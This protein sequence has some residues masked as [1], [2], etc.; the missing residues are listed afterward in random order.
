MTPAKGKK[1]ASSPAARRKATVAARSSTSGAATGASRKPAAGKAASG[2]T[3]AKKTAARKASGA[4]TP[5]R[6]TPARKTPARKSSS[7]KIA[8]AKSPAKK[9]P[10]KKSPA[11]KSP[12]KKSP[13]RKSADRT[14]RATKPA[15]RG[16]G[17]RKAAGG[18][19]SSSTATKKGRGA[20]TASP[21]TPAPKTP[22]PSTAARKKAAAASTKQPTAPSG[23]PRRA[24]DRKPLIRRGAA[25]SAKTRSR[26]PRPLK[27]DKSALKG[28]RER[29][30]AELDNLRARIEDIDETVFQGT[31]S[32]VT[33]EAG[34]DEA[35]ADAGTATFERER[36]LSIRNNIGDLIDQITRA[37]ARI[38]AGT[39][40]SCE[41]CGQPIDGAR[42]KALPHALLC[43]DCKRRE[44]RAR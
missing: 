30:V 10:A 19:S 22:S 16:G 17:R 11:K 23:T 18:R 35:F 32:D 25:A 9:S 15:V 41:R 36:D 14:G 21:K 39:Y 4:K 3:S 28:V 29:L 1:T 12:A 24:V 31:Q 40:G 27:L 33:G 42:L 34:L 2:K 43:M 37:I 44:E 5:A 38:D 8:A 13:A 26:A 6:K 20:A 7:R